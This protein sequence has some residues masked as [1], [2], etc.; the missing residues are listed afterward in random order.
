MSQNIFGGREGTSQGGSEFKAGEL[1]TFK[2]S[3]GALE[4]FNA[5]APMIMSV[6]LYQPLRSG[7]IV[8]LKSETKTAQGTIIKIEGGREIGGARLG[9]IMVT[10][11]KLDA[12]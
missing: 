8:S 4:K 6:N 11:E 1:N 12:K 10:V 3:D 2:V 5:G 9:N 7:D